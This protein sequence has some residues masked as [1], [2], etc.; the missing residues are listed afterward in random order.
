MSALGSSPLQVVVRRTS[1]GDQISAAEVGLT[2]YLVLLLLFPSALSLAAL[3]GAG[4]PSTLWGLLLGMWWCADRLRHGSPR[5][6]RTLEIGV[7]VFVLSVLV[8]YLV[9]TIRPI[10]TFERGSLD[11]GLIKTLS[12]ASVALVATDGLRT[13]EAVE[14]VLRRAVVMVGANAALGIAQF[15]TGQ[16]LLGWF[17]LPGFSTSSGVSNLLGRG[18]LSRARGTAQHPLEFVSMLVMTLPLALNLARFGRHPK[19]LYVISA[20]LVGAVLAV[21]L[22]RSA[23]IGALLALFVAALAWTRKALA[24]VIIGVA[25][26]GMITYAVVPDVIDTSLALF[27]GIST[28]SSALSRVNGI[29]VALFFWEQSP[30]IGRGMG[31]FLPQ[32]QILDNQLLNLLVTNGVVGVAAF[33]F[34]FGAAIFCALQ[35]RTRIANPFDEFSQITQGFIAAAAG[36]TLL[37]AFFDAFSF[38]KAAGMLFLVFGLCGAARSA[39]A[40]EPDVVVPASADPAS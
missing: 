39:V 2:V 25:F 22:S 4:T 9:G 17:S 1:D 38:P 15:V 34:L 3:G 33:A 23:I 13:R 8:S 31:T 12:W 24:A 11:A 10:P 6:S 7:V 20:V 5:T 26:A 30:I 18:D 29:R 32:Y 27:T 36:G 19:R 21:S 35:T 28:D 37:M 14:R 40:L 16:S